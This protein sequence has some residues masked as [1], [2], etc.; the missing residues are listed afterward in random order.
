MR[1]H[2]PLQKFSPSLSRYQPL[3]L[4]CWPLVILESRDYGGIDRGP[5]SGYQI[6]QFFTKNAPVT[7]RQCDQEAE[8]ITGASATPS[9][10]QDLNLELLGY[11]EAAYPGFVPHH[12]HAGKLEDLD[13]YLMNKIGG[14]SMYLAREELY[15]NDFQLLHQT[16]Q[17]Y[18]RFFASAWHSTPTNMPPPDRAVLLADYSSQLTHFAAG[19]PSRFRQT[20]D[21]LIARL[22]GLFAKDW[23]MV[24]NHIDLLE[25]NLHVDPGTGRLVGV[26]DWRDV[27]ISPFG[28]SL[29]GLETMLGMDRMG[30]GWCYHANH[31]ALRGVFWGA[32]NQAMGDPR[33]DD[34]V[35]VA[36]LAGI[37]LA[38]GWEY[39][40]ADE[41][42]VVGEGSYGFMYLDAAVLGNFTAASHH[43]SLSPGCQK[44]LLLRATHTVREPLARPQPL[45][46]PPPR[47]LALLPFP[48]LLPFPSPSSRRRLKLS[49][50]RLPRLTTPGTP[51]PPFIQRAPPRIR[52]ARPQLPNVNPPSTPSFLALAKLVSSPSPSSPPP[53]PEP[54]PEPE[55]P[56][57]VLLVLPELGLGL[58]LR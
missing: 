45:F 3:I 36:R 11:A 48:T 46:H 47:L 18:A 5:V 4:S 15:R 51:H 53:P 29:C 21:S 42:V 14:I 8:R 58:R 35:E 28:M 33:I 32:F 37:F 22:P 20:L 44:P 19:L 9:T 2:N 57:P 41:K 56:L 50:H 52:M 16:L 10:V 39:N 23:P 34:R 43:S 40:E 31:E 24:P 26:C 17:D 55:P 7:Q 49:P 1:A 27:E 25:N 12:Q 38:N 30:R 54:E 13:V 6:S